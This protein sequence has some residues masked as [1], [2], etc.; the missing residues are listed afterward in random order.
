MDQPAPTG[1]SHSFGNASVRFGTFEVDL[2]AGELRKGGVKIKLYGQPF[3]VLAILLERPGEVVSRE[4]LQQ[5]L[6]AGDT[7]VDFEHGL[8]KAIN[9]VREALGDDADNPRFIETLPR[10][11]YRFIAPMESVS[12]DLARPS[13][14]KGPAPEKEVSAAVSSAG[15]SRRQV[16][17]WSISSL[18]IAA[19]LGL[20]A[21]FL[22]TSP[23]PARPVT[24]AVIT[25]PPG[26]HLAGLERPAL[27]LS[28]DGNKLA[29][30]AAT[31]GG[32]PQIYL[33]A[34]DS[35]EVR[36]IP[37]TQGAT[38][39][40]FSPD[41]QWLGFISSGKLKKISV[42]GGVAVTL[43]DVDA[44]AGATWGGRHTIIFAPAGSVL[45][46]VS[47]EGGVPQPVTQFEPGESIQQW[48]EILPGGRAVIFV[49]L[50]GFTIAVQPIGTSGRRKLSPQQVGVVPHYAPSGHLLY[51]VSA[52][53]M[54]VPFNLNR[55][56]VGGAAVPVVQ[57]VL[58][59]QTGAA[60]YSVSATGSLVY[61]PGGMQGILRRPVWVSRNGAEQPLAAPA[62]VYNQPRL[63]PD[64]RQ[65]ALDIVRNQSRQVW[66]YDLARDTL[67]QLTSEGTTNEM[68]AWTPDGKR[69]AFTS[70]KEGPLH[71]FWQPADGGG[72]PERL[73]TNDNNSAAP[74]SWSPD[75]QLLAFVEILPPA[76]PKIF[77][78]RMADRSA[79][80]FFQSQ[81]IEDAP[82]FSPDGHWL[83]Y[84]TNESGRREIYVK[85]YPGPGGRWQIS[86]EGG[87]EPVW[88]RSGRELFYR[89]GDK[90]M[91][92]DIT[93]EPSFA[94]GKPRQLF[95]GDYVSTEVG[96][97]RPD[98]D[99]SPDGQRFFMLK[100]IEQ[101]QA[102]TQINIV[103]NWTEELKRLVPTG[104]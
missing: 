91:A 75:G 37:D 100:P 34:M 26:Q 49:S 84:A 67:S 98:Y 63:S 29:Y 33:R 10:R 41:G 66:V 85:P 80:P 39:P 43:A 68:P 20:T 70:N 55:L 89:S 83:A 3:N 24:R 104:K 15:A 5:K 45:R 92:V 9:K 69:I 4:E 36:P 38:N 2:R 65:I 23:A 32:A 62:D 93:T 95:E 57:G 13:M 94:A 42:N 8:N 72:R 60:Q 48:P 77:L 51:V 56:Q 79:Q 47:D 101:E 78:Q 64:G 16:L 96:L 44:I 73:T 102:P 90:M 30:V 97:A 82:Q 21:W 86:T 99:V 76:N 40:F 18:A 59:S 53:L 71:I 22:K 88:N 50:F 25:L 6:W 12:A 1:S 19:I 87:T 17:L 81:A 46:Q 14:M 28:A 58:Q 52:N 61:V 35:G 11:G 103:L 7:F 31:Q 54:A 74:F 27:A